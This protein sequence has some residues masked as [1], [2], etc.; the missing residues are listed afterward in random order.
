MKTPLPFVLSAA[1]IFLA[2]SPAARPA[3]P[4]ADASP[5]PVDATAKTAPT[6]RVEFCHWK[7]GDPPLRLIR[8]EEGFCALT[9]VSGRFEGAGEQA[10]VYIG[11]DG[12]WYLGG[13]SNQEGVSADCMVVRLSTAGS[14]L[15][16]VRPTPD[17]DGGVE[18]LAASYSYGSEYA[19][20]TARVR[21]LVRAGEEF[22][23][24][25]DTLGVD[26][27][28]YMNKALVIFCTVKGK[29]AI[30]SVGEDEA[31]SRALLLEKA[32]PVSGEAAVKP[33]PTP[34]P[35]P[36]TVA[37]APA[38]FAAAKDLF[39]RIDLP[40]N[41]QGHPIPQTIRLND[42]VFEYGGTRYSGFRFVVDRTA[43][44]T[45]QGVAD[46]TKMGLFWFFVSPCGRYSW[47]IVPVEGEMVGFE[48]YFPLKLSSFQGTESYL[49]EKK[50]QVIFQNLSAD[51]L[52]EGHEYIIWFILPSDM[53]GPMEMTISLGFR[54]DQRRY[55]RWH[56]LADA[57]AFL[58]LV[59]K[60][61]K[62]DQH[63][64]A[65]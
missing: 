3:E 47:Y 36:E 59:P 10:R 26:P 14:V 65:E 62:V 9:A 6:A 13:Q 50:N 23:A 35:E 48:N 33:T 52:V 42:K 20:V 18:I 61:R 27:H 54:D 63:D 11:D 46:P 12:Y 32:R 55:G 39:P 25:P 8:Q 56:N 22:A 30:Y 7:Q 2:T 4:S 16:P 64:A 40:T 45:K 19:D 38:D 49:P 60:Q 51:R 1:L 57:V 15:A 44:A 31:I 24:N 34:T 43:A 5:P 17:P 53:K 21:E 41:D 58:G 29:R 37:P 28:P